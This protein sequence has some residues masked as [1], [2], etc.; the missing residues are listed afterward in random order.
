MKTT[1]A[2]KIANEKG[3]KVE[4]DGTVISPSG[5][6][7]K[8]QKSS[9]GYNRFNV[10]IGDSKRFPIGVHKLQAYQKFGDNALEEDVHV[11]HLNGNPL[12]NTYD[13]IAIGTCR[14]NI[15]DR[16]AL[17]RSNQAKHASSY[18]KSTLPEE[19][20]S[21]IKQEYKNGKSY[22]E[23]HK[24]FGI[25]KSTLS[26]HL[27][28]SAKRQSITDTPVINNHVDVFNDTQWLDLVGTFIIENNISQCS[29][30]HNIPIST[31]R[32]RFNKMYNMI[33]PL[34]KAIFFT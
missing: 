21:L 11:R 10:S 20:L 15:L 29:R 7:R 33:D 24:Q 26:Y 13:N 28:E 4:K 6:K 18:R 23:L 2:I 3:Y 19:T 31:I 22:N 32:D 17:S 9:T 34:E 8:L 12:D 30:V 1:Q 27:S 14:E 5:K 16:E 25:S